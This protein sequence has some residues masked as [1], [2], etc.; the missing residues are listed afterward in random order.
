[1]YVR[2]LNGAEYAVMATTLD[3]ITLN[4]DHIIDIELEYNKP[5]SIFMDEIDKLWEFIDN[6]GTEFKIL[7]MQ[8]KG[9]GEW[10][11]IVLKAIPL[12]FDYLNTDR[13]YEEYNGSMTFRR[14]VEVI[15]EGTPYNFVIGGT[16][17]AIDWENFGGGETKLKSLERLLKRSGAEIKIVGNNVHFRNLIGEDTNIMYA[18]RL[19]A[20]DIVLNVDATEYFTYA[21]GFGDY[22]DEDGVENAKLIREYTSPLAS[23]LGKRHAPPIK[24]GRIKNVST[25]DENLKTLV[26]DS[27]KISVEANMHMLKKQGYSEYIPEIGDRVF[28]TDPRI[29]LDEEV[30]VINLKIKRDWRGRI[31]DFEAT[32]GTHSIVKRHQ[33]N[34]SSAI[35]QITNLLE[36]KT[37]LPFSVLDNA[38][39][40]ATKALQNAESEL[41][42]PE[43]G[44]ILAVDKTNPN[45]VTIYNSAGIGVS[46]DGGKTFKNA[47]T[48]EGIVAEA[49]I[50]GVVE[51]LI[52]NGGEINGGKFTTVGGNNRIEV[53]RGIID[54]YNGTS[55]SSRLSGSGHHFYKGATYGGYIGV[56]PRLTQ[57]SKI[58]LSFNLANGMD[59]MAWTHDENGDGV[60][61][62]KL[63]WAKDN[64]IT[65]RNKG[66]NFLDDVT[67]QNIDARVIQADDVRAGSKARISSS[68][69][70]S[71][72]YA[73]DNVWLYVNESGE[74]GINFGGRAYSIYK[75]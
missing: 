25:M 4:G 36:G 67:A 64:S 56:I 73:S 30:R 34:L 55:L 19:N 2:D 8:K 41:I 59:F 60:Y 53:S 20:S 21:R 24:D 1:M 63:I 57:Q 16:F 17:S 71:R 49:I 29:Q 44:G 35:D 51:G 40:H 54:I 72:L 23:V 45:L 15:F 11:R 9:V 70:G 7:N 37:K 66:F 31:L 52:I 47:I 43:T 68:L 32:L 74:V 75:V 58:G 46:K 12:F 50:A 6:E 42:F 39:I 22:S 69:N 18:H 26:D 27:L 38:V 65:G 3:D 61:N 48:G 10:Q 62:D 5:N 28:V 13:I 33:S 14:S